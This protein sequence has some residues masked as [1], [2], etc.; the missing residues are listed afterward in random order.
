VKAVSKYNYFLKY[1]K[2]QLI[3]LALIGSGHDRLISLRKKLSH[4]SREKNLSI[5]NAD[6]L[7]FKTE[8]EIS[9]FNPINGDTVLFCQFFNSS[10]ERNE[11]HISAIYKNINNEFIKNIVIYTDGNTS[12]KKI[13]E[14]IKS[15]DKTDIIPFDGKASFYDFINYFKNNFKKTD[16]CLISN[17]DCFYDPSIKILK[18]LNF[19]DGNNLFCCTRKEKLSTGDISYAVDP[20]IHLN[21]KDSISFDL[22]N[23]NLDL[24]SSD[25][26]I[27]NGD[28]P[29]SSCYKKNFLGSINTEYNFLSN[30]FLQ[31]KKIINLFCFLNCIHL[32]QLRTTNQHSKAEILINKIFPNP[33]NNKTT[34]KNYIYGTWR[35]RCPENYI[36]KNYPIQDFGDFLP[37]NSSSLFELNPNISKNLTKQNTL[38]L[39]YL[40]TKKEYDDGLLQNSF[41]SFFNL[42]PSLSFKIKVYLFS[43][44]EINKDELIE[45]LISNC[46]YSEF[47][48]RI[49]YHS[50]DIPPKDNIY[51]K[52]INKNKDHEVPKLGLSSGPNFMFFKALEFLRGTDFKNF[53]LLEPDSTCLKSYWLD[54]LIDSCIKRNFLIQGGNYSGLNQS[55]YNAYYSDHINGLAIYKNHNSLHTLIN[56]SKELI[57]ESVKSNFIITPS[58]KKHQINKH[59]SFDVALF[60][61][62]SK[63]KCLSKYLVSNLFS[64]KTDV[65]DYVVTTTEVLSDNPDAIILHQKKPNPRFLV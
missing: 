31:G 24:S 41:R 35:L 60:L 6:F 64:I 17:C 40:F 42:L 22:N 39:F 16:V 32:H 23:K 61:I 8:S 46:Q 37:L 43:D 7:S 1:L 51:I 11:D 3:S 38:C 65:E 55:N 56:K 25:C 49:T 58:Q 54:T 18:Y 26:F 5:I 33:Y 45:T 2:T 15:H 9:N 14:E 28:F 44:I 4:R 57:I 30:Q 63:Q 48:D 59:L 47:I 20:L 34:T 52:E 36:D 62:F 21:N 10:Q 19:N 13:P 50:L 29:L 12:L 53:I 27:I